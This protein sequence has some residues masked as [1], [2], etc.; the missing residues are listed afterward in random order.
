MKKCNHLY[1][2]LI[3]NLIF[4]SLLFAKQI[5][6]LET[7][8]SKETPT[9]T[10]ANEVLQL[11]Q[12]M[13]D[14]HEV[15]ISKNIQYWVMGGTL[16]GAIRHNGI[17]PWDDDLDI[18]IDKKQE[19]DFISLKPIFKQLKCN[20][21]QGT[22]GYKI[23]QKDSYLPFIDVFLYEQNGNDITYKWKF[24]NPRN[25]RNVPIYANELFPIK[26]YKF[27][28]LFVKGPKNPHPYLICCYGEKYMD[29]AVYGHAHGKN[30]GH[31]KKGTMTLT[32]KDRIPA[33]PT[34][35]LQDRVSKILANDQFTL[36]TV[37]ISKNNLNETIP[38]IEKLCPVYIEAFEKESEA[39]LQKE[40]PEEY[41]ELQHKGLTIK[42]VLLIR[43]NKMIDV[44]ISKIDSV[45]E[46]YIS[47]AKDDNDEVIGYNIFTQAP[48]S[49]TIQSMVSRNYITSVISLSEEILSLNNQNNDLYILS[50]AVRPA[51][52]KMGWGKK[53]IFSALDQCSQAKN[54]YLL[55]AASEQNKDTQEFYEHI[56]FKAKGLFL[57]CD[58]N[59]KILYCL[60]TKSSNTL[61]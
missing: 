9:I 54:I 41:N 33:M 32:K 49:Q 22:F 30:K 53:L 56:N 27:G 18:C 46:S 16:L 2:G 37:R 36:E 31:V 8:T 1:F 58:K 34:G 55:T 35:P 51:F 14:V 24:K 21:S 40:H 50:L 29:E 10:R 25:N 3:L 4:C 57:T 23:S 48:I 7:H 20:V 45:K 38:L 5:T 42:D 13:K 15:L 26:D 19:A 43:F 6:S 17:I 60:D 44:F 39:Q 61:K 59:E 28:N 12:L 11:Y 52:Q 47:V